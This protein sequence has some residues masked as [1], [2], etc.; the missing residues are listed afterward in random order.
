MAFGVLPEIVRDFQSAYREAKQ[1]YRDT[2][3]VIAERP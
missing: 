2:V 1:Q 3:R